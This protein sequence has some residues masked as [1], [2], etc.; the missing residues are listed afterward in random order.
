MCLSLLYMHRPLFQRLHKLQL[1]LCSLQ[2]NVPQRVSL[3]LH[4][5]RRCMLSMQ[6]QLQQ[7]F[8]ESVPQLSFRILSRPSGEVLKARLL[9]Q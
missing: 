1:N 2:R 8:G 4:F 9:P 3:R 5:C 6:R 7:M